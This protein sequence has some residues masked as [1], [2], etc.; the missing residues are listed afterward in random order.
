MSLLEHLEDVGKGWRSILTNLHNGLEVVAPS[1]TVVQVKE[2]FG[3]LRVYL[4]YEDEDKAGVHDLIYL[5]EEQ[6]LRTCEYCG[7]YGE[8]GGKGWVKTLCEEC[9][10]ASI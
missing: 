4:S 3:G 1:Y 5:A 2:K 8:P 9:R 7:N 10:D 6:S